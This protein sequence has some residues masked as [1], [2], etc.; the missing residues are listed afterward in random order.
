MSTGGW[1]KGLLSRSYRSAFVNQVLFHTCIKLQFRFVRFYF[2]LAS[3]HNFDILG[4]ISHSHQC[5]YLM[6][7]SSTLHIIWM[8]IYVWI[9][10]Y[11][12]YT[13]LNPR[14]FLILEEQRIRYNKVY[15]DMGRLVESQLELNFQNIKLI[16]SRKICWKYF[17]NISKIF[18]EYL[19]NI[20]KIKFPKYFQNIKL[21][22]SPSY[23]SL[24]LSVCIA[25]AVSRDFFR[26]PQ[27][28]W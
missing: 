11:T 19:L 20:S 8:Y 13:C 21:I 16:L 27:K 26:T 9:Y 15:W 22:L 5:Q 6:W 12:F 3:N 10:I 17:L 2:T 23:H 28:R 7:L 24:F 4:F 1:S 25:N 18:P 14:Y